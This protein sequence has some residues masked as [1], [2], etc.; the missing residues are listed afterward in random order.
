MNLKLN[1]ADKTYVVKNFPSSNDDELQCTGVLNQFAMFLPNLATLTE[2]LQQLEKKDKSG[3]EALHKLSPLKR[4]NRS[5]VLKSPYLLPECWVIMIGKRRPMHP[6]CSTSRSVV[7]HEINYA[8]SEIQA[9][10]ATWASET[11]AN[12]LLGTQFTGHSSHCFPHKI[13]SNTIQ[14]LFQERKWKTADAF[15][16][17]PTEQ[18]SGSDMTFIEEVETYQKLVLLHLPCNGEMPAEDLI[19]SRC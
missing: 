14:A 5:R 1:G 9:L 19:C 8:T 3:T 15:F 17:T 6:I 2:P 16:H 12:Y 13:W 7:E 10:A 11:F 4:S 18:P